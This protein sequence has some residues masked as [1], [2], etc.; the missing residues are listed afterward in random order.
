M[1]HI[2][3]KIF[4]SPMEYYISFDTLLFLDD[5]NETYLETNQIGD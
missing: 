2:F 4:F 3:K 5:Q 1:W